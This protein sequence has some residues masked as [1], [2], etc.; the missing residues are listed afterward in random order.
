M[1]LLQIPLRPKDI[2]ILTKHALVS[3]HPHVVDENVRTPWDEPTADGI[4]FCRHLPREPV[5]EGGHQADAFVQDGLEVG[6]LAGFLVGNRERGDQAGADGGGNLGL[7]ADVGAGSGEEVEHGALEGGGGGVG[8]GG[9]LGRDFED[10]GPLGDA[11]FD[12]F[13]LGHVSVG[14]E[15]RMKTGL[16]VQ[17]CW[18]GLCRL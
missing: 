7:E 6:K 3:Q 2:R 4:P 18:S 14:L 16:D 12:P 1:T 17:A 5:H 13:V 9:E 11:V 10:G 8:A 15:K